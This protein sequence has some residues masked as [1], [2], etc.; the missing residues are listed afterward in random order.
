VDKE[1]SYL[2]E[3]RAARAQAVAQRREV[4]KALSEG[5]KGSHAEN[6]STNLITLQNTIEAI[7]RA[8]ADEERLA[9]EPGGAS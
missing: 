2:K 4:T 9:S 1:N 5:Y 8:I 3:L 6:M 7:D